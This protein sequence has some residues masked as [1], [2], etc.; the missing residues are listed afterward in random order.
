MPSANG[1][2][3]IYFHREVDARTSLWSDSSATDEMCVEYSFEDP[4]RA[5]GIFKSCLHGLNALGQ[6]WDLFVGVDRFNNTI[7]SSETQVGS[8]QRQISS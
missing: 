4:K 7:R 1:I 6:C 5:A 2:Y 3:W 8:F